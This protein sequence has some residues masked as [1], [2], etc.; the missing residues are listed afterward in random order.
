MDR[1]EEIRQLA[2]RLW[3]QEGRGAGG[4]MERWL[5]AEAMWRE[6]QTE[7]QPSQSPATS[8]EAAASPS[9]AASPRRPRAKGSKGK[10]DS[11]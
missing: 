5:R 8:T 10:P 1:E 2:Y 4:E 6:E 3:E 11:T 9:H 7:G